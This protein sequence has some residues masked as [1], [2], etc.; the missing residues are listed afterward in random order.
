MIINKTKI[1]LQVNGIN[2]S[3][4]MITNNKKK[5]SHPLII[6]IIKIYKLVKYDQKLYKKSKLIQNNKN[7]NFKNFNKSSK[8]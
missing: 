3:A 2:S 7:K 5:F 1:I 4:V 6:I 8:N